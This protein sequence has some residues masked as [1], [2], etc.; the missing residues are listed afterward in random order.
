MTVTTVTT[1][2]AAPHA[3]HV[4]QHDANAPE[5]TNAVASLWSDTLVFAGRNLAH[6][7]QLP[8]KL[9]DVT[10]Q[11]LMFVLLFTYVFGGAIAVQNSN[12]REYVIAGILVQSLAF[13]LVGPATGIATD[14]LEGVID[15]FRG[16]PS[17]RLAYLLGH[18]VA[19]LASMFLAISVL[20][21]AGL[22]VGWRPH[23]DV[24]HVVLAIVLLGVFASSMIWFGTF[25]GLI[26][27]T[28]DAVMGVGFTVVFPI[29][30]ISNAF[31]PIDSM[32][33]VL[34]KF[35]TWNPVSVMVAA[36]RELFG[37]PGAPPSVSSWPMDNPV[38]ASFLSCGIVLLL[39]VPATL[40]R[41]RH[42][43]TD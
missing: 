35:A 14:L 4:S 3:V 8:E 22:L 41:Y 18:Y 15:R 16:L 13:G 43:T 20:L 34:Q 25:L 27:R 12:Y 33:V 32:P 39:V 23:T 40:R 17:S 5:R 29:T 36:V 10:V 6:V 30:F 21:G 9:L 31:V 1:P 11:P 38:L 7:R 28:P 19:E 26:V 24:L 42:R 2:A 37:N